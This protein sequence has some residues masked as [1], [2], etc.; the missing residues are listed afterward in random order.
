MLF[1][2]FLSHTHTPS[3]SLSLFHT[4]SLLSDTYGSAQASEQ[5]GAGRVIHI[6]NRSEEKDPLSSIPSSCVSKLLLT[7]FFLQ[8]LIFFLHNPSF[9]KIHWWVE[10]KLGGLPLY[11]KKDY[12]FIIHLTRISNVWISLTGGVSL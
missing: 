7:L 1:S 8:S 4:H 12:S 10:G 2:L 5:D 6:G 11:R 9:L 3:L